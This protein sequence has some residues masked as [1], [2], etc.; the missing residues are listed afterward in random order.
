MRI[1]SKL[2]LS[3]CLLVFLFIGCSKDKLIEMHLEK[4]DGVWNIDQVTWTLVQQSTAHGQQISS[5]TTSNAGTFTFVKGGS[6]TY[7]YNVA[8]TIQRSGSFN[9]SV[10]NQKVSL[11]RVSQ[12]ISFTSGNIDQRSLVY[13]GTQ[14][15]KTKL[16]FSGS[17]TDQNYSGDITQSVFTGTFTLTKK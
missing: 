5:N 12:S 13:N 8:D 3:L 1:Y 6:G 17:E 9:W 11:I 15:S 14:P 10:S 7:T 4:K 16:T 2:T